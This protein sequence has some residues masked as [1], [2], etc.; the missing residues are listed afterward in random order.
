[1]LKTTKPRE[2]N[3]KRE[4]L[5]PSTYPWEEDVVAVAIVVVVV[6]VIFMLLV[7]FA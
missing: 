7:G 2:R 4:Y 5:V 1:M 3:A 6:V